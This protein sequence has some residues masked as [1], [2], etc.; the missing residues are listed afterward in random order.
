LF[1]D[2]VFTLIVIDGKQTVIWKRS[3]AKGYGDLEQIVQAVWMTIVGL[4]ASKHN[5]LFLWA[6]FVFLVFQINSK[7]FIHTLTCTFY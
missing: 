5:Q 2:G 7:C 6:I 3:S 4:N 1:V